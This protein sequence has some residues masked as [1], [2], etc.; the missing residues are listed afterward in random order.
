MTHYK[1]LSLLVFL[2]FLTDCK[3]QTSEQEFY[4]EEFK[5]KI[6]I[7]NGFEK[8]ETKEWNDYK[9]KGIKAIEETFD[10]KL[11][12]QTR[13]LFSFKNGEQ[14]IFESV[15]QPYD[16][17]ING[18]Y[19]ESQKYVKYIIYKTVK[20]NVK[21]AKIDTLSF[22]KTISGKEFDTFKITVSYPNKFV[23]NTLMYSRLFDK[24]EFTVNI[25]YIDKNEGKKMIEKWENSVFE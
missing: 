25:I 12:N 2:T 13:T 17:E 23:M 4:S 8:I 20:E 7:P 9:E 6:N 15:V 16:A 5:W 3:C 10:K 1:L 22:K 19:S 11:E 14:N 24:T 21:G 18:E